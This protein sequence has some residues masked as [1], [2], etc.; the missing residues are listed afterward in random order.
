MPL[1]ER[2]CYALFQSVF[3]TAIVII[4]QPAS[5]NHGLICKCPWLR[6][7][8]LRVWCLA[9][10]TVQVDVFDSLVGNVLQMQPSF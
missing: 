10:C 1:A 3:F 9:Y 6:Q 4:A 2:H 7:K 8:I 5:A